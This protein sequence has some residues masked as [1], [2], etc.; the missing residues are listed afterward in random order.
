M[1]LNGNK[2]ARNWRNHAER[3]P[4]LGKQATGRRRIPA[5]TESANSVD[6]NLKNDTTDEIIVGVDREIGIGFAVGANYIWRRY[7]DFQ[8]ND[9]TGITT[10]DWVAVTF[11]ACGLH[12]PGQ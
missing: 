7:S 11:H 9:R 2:S 1:D 10:A 8:W 4:A 12:V 3:E 6:P 5:N